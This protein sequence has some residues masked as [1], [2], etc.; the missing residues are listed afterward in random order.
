MAATVFLETLTTLAVGGLVSV[1]ILAVARWQ[2][3]DSY[4]TQWR[5]IVGAVG[6]TL[7]VGLPTV[8]AICGRLLRILGVT[9][10]NPTAAQK[11]SAVRVRTF[12]L[13]GCAIALGWLVQGISLWATLGL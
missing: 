5:W 10:I 7:I 13:G 4:P 3:W 8:P 12:A 2:G 9:R 11:L 6:M 1:V